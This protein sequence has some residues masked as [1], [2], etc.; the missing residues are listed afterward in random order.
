MQSSN[1]IVL[2]YD[3][4]GDVKPEHGSFYQKKPFK[5]TKLPLVPLVETLTQFSTDGSASNATS[6]L[7]LQRTGFKT[8]SSSHLKDPKNPLRVDCREMIS[9]C[10]NINDNDW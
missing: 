10:C 4:D 9:T 5:A 1:L 6:A 8:P 7:R 3:R 2:T